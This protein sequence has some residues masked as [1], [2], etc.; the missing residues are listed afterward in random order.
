MG[1]IDW[2]KKKLKD[3]AG[4]VNQHIVQPAGRAISGA[5][6]AAKRLPG[7]VADAV[8]NPGQT[9]RRIA[10]A[11]SL[12]GSGSPL[13]ASGVLASMASRPEVQNAATGVSN[14]LN[15]ATAFNPIARPL[16]GAENIAKAFQANP[17]P[18]V[19]GIT[20][21]VGDLLRSGTA[22][23]RAIQELTSGNVAGA[24][25]A[26]QQSPLLQRSQE[27]R[28]QGKGVVGEFAPAVGLGAEVGTTV[29]PF[30][31]LKGGS[32]AVRAGK[33]ALAGGVAGGGFESGRQLY[34]NEPF[35]PAQVGIATGLGAATVGA[36]PLAGAAVG[37]L[38]RG[39][40]NIVRPSKS[41][42]ITPKGQPVTVTQSGAPELQGISGAEAK[43]AVNAIR[44][45]G[46]V[47]VQPQ[48]V[49]TETIPSKLGQLRGAR[50]E[51]QTRP[52]IKIVPRSP[53]DVPNVKP[54]SNLNADE[55]IAGI[56]KQESLARKSGGENLVDE[57]RKKI[58]D[59]LAPVEKPLNVARRSASKRGEPIKITLDPSPQFDRVLRAPS[60]AGQYA[61]DRG[62]VKLVQGIPD[63]KKFD[64]YAKAKHALTLESQGVRTGR[65]LS[66]DKALVSALSGEYDQYAQEAT[67]YAHDMLD[68]MSAPVNELLP[69][70]SYGYGLITPEVSQALKQRYPNYVPFDRIFS[71]IESKGR[72]G[73]KAVGS[74]S[75]QT[76]VQRIKGSDR[77]VEPVLESLAKRTSQM[78]EQGE[79]N[80][81]AY[82]V[83]QLE[84]LP[85][86][87]G[88]IRKV[89]PG[90]SAPPHSFSYLENGRKVGYE[91]TP[92]IAGALKRL[93]VENLGAL[94]K[95]FA[96]PTRIF[97]VGTTGVE[98]SFLL[99]NLA[100][101]QVFAFMTT[102]D[103]LRTSVAN[104][105]VFVKAM[106]A[107]TGRGKLYQEMLREGATQ[108][109]FDISRN[110]LPVTVSRIRAERNAG[111]KFL[112]NVRHP[113][114]FWRA[115]E[116]IVG[117]TE[118]QTRA[119]QYAGT[120]QGALSRGATKAEARVEAARAARE[121]TANFNRSG[122]W[123]PAMRSAFA[124]L[125]AGIQGS[126]S[127]VRGFQ[128]R[129]AETTFKVA[130][131][132]LLPA[133]VIT[134]FNLSDPNRKKVWQDIPN[135]EKD[136]NLLL[137]LNDNQDENGRYTGILKIPITPG[138]S[139]LMYPVRQ[140]IEVA[141]GQN[142][143]SVN[144]MFAQLLGTVSPVDVTS[145]NSAL[146]SL[147]PQ[148]VK[149]AFEDISNFD[150]FTGRAI[151]PDY[152]QNRPVEEQYNTKTSGVSILLGKLFNKS[153]LKIDH[154][155]KAIFGKL[156]LEVTHGLDVALE[157]TGYV[158]QVGGVSPTEAISQ[159]FVSATG[160]SPDAR[161]YQR[162]EEILKGLPS[163]KQRAA[164]EFLRNY[165]RP[166]GDPWDSRAKATVLL[167]DE[168]LRKAVSEI[169]STK[170][171]SAH[172]PLFD[173]TD[174]QQ[175]QV[176]LSRYLPPGSDPY[177]YKTKL[178]S[179]DWVKEFQK[180][181]SSYFESL[182]SNKYVPGQIEKKLETYNKLPDSKKNTYLGVN[183][184]IARYLQE[185]STPVQSS[186]RPQASPELQ[187]KLDYYNTLPKG[188]GARSQ[189][190]ASNPDVVQF[191]TQS[192]LF[193]NQQLATMGLIPGDQV[194]S[195]SASG[196]YRRSSRKGRGGRKTVKITSPKLKTGVAK[197]R[198]P[199]QKKR[200]S[201]A[202]K[203][204]P[205]KGKVSSRT[206]RA[207]KGFTSRRASIKIKKG[208]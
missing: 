90:E 198:K 13:G 59:Y 18:V 94:G 7:Q 25:Q 70:G 113:G 155:I 206:Y 60:I 38:G 174:E 154:D 193:S 204:T 171:G 187:S 57:A 189:F 110:Q 115:L 163:D 117:A 17:V 203:V 89:T 177:G 49:I 119:Q 139:N 83:G 183:P 147:A 32:L 2:A 188:T 201:T 86:F 35:N 178:Y 158:P 131:G 120:Y 62:L 196:A 148:A 37:K 87:K 43:Q 132:L 51:V 98:P 152:L 42:K 104:P 160:T 63:I 34:E 195:F 123:G 106:F 105:T 109:S 100:R 173:L 124:Y 145:P 69:D 23:V 20:R 114:E 26:V 186:D 129:P 138:L 207:P 102:K 133:A 54:A 208:A 66:K 200:K 121:N 85:E 97:K 103:A 5:V 107:A 27:A 9:I 1:L 108:T 101:D 99:T 96:A 202:I 46:S 45:Q 190:L 95:I 205:T 143:D 135:F 77:Q 15:Q 137:I 126:R 33:G 31:A 156:G 157:G 75:N 150:T 159:R 65:D 91:T 84:K 40:K 125:N 180:K 166:T 56:A 153:P 47:N 4:W 142:P 140:A 161:Y 28:Q 111:A 162:V 164:Y 182:K 116:N 93:G 184:D 175:K 21:P 67:R 192:K 134:Q 50:P 10:P 61:E 39:I 24:N 149:P 199:T 141:H 151:V 179:Q 170:P 72:L 92:E 185:Q 80:R 22:P 112:Y 6:G 74:L 130:S 71:E 197:A 128:R 36:T 81:A 181:E 165:E 64:Q 12:L 16:T 55:Y 127:L 172:D 191:F 168:S 76:V 19:K 88:L 44:N 52:G 144:R 29:A 8:Q 3:V 73:T 167:Q 41:V 78:V 194:G 11:I 146:S 118:I 176:L 30:P 68:R 136:N 53:N 122:E 14:V 79:K 82:M 58:I 48:N 169:K